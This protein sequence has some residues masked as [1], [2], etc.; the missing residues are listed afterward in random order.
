MSA[1]SIISSSPSTAAIPASFPVFSVSLWQITPFPPRA[2]SGKLS[3]AVRLPKPFSV[4]DNR[5]RETAPSSVR[6]NTHAPTTLSPSPSLMPLTPAACLPIMRAASSLNLIPRPAL[7]AINICAFPSVLLTNNSS[8]PS[9]RSIARIP[10]FFMRLNRFS[11]HLFIFPCLVTMTRYSSVFSFPTD[12]N[13]VTCSSCSSFNML[14]MFVPFAV[15]EASGI[16]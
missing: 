13:A 16:S 6:T 9:R 3:S 7:V 8:S 15:L 4:I 1:I 11:R 12:I 10:F 14:T 2:R 5:S